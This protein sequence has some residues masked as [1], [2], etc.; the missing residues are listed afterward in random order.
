M[1]RDATADELLSD[2]ARGDRAAFRSLYAREGAKLFALSLRILRDRAAAEDAVQDAFVDIWRKASVF[3][4]A[5]GSAAAW[6]ATIVRSRSIDLLRRRGR[7]APMGDAADLDLLAGSE[8]APGADIEGIALARCVRGLPEEQRQM[9]L[10]AYLDGASRD[11]LAERFG[12]PV[13]T[14]KTLLRR[15]LAALRACLGG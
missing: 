8:S 12:R 7:L 4:P 9:I 6:L 14:V 13:N 5:R 15:G 11:E 2:A 10:L 1:G 3:D